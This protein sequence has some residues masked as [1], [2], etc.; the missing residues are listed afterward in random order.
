MKN[1]R[2]FAAIAVV[3]LGAAA[4]AAAGPPPSLNAPDLAQ[5]PYGQMHMRLQKTMLKINVADVDVRVDRATQA[6]IAQAAGGQTYSFDLDHRVAPL[7]IAAPRAVV[8][9]EFV[10][11]V[12]LNRWM[13]VVRD[14]LE[15]AR[16][17]GLI[18]REVEHRVSD[19]LPTWFAAL[20]DRGYL[21]GDRV[22]YSVTPNDLRT[23][24]VSAGGQVLMDMS[25]PGTEARQVVLASYF[26]PKSDTR[27]PLLRSLLSSKQ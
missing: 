24:V 5:G 11:D 18:T 1:L 2:R 12:P 22:I 27:E 26:A 19:A 15:Q 7:V 6:K 9:M 14:N 4:A 3:T 13:G 8:Q 25:Q 21:K 17:A 20:K 16:E 10:R 23:V